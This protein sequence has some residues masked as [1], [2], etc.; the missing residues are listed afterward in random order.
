MEQ[1]HF[2]ID[3]QTEILK[4][5][6]TDSNNYKII[7]LYEPHYFT[8]REHSIIAAAFKAYYKEKNRLPNK[9]M[10]NETIRKLITMPRYQKDIKLI[11]KEQLSKLVNKI[12]R[13][14]CPN[15]EEI[16]EESKKFTRYQ[17]LREI[18]EKGD[19]LD[20]TRYD[21]FASSIQQAISFGHEYE[22]QKGLFL[23]RDAKF[24]HVDRKLSEPTKPLPY[25]QWNR[26]TNANGYEKG[27]VVC[28]VGKEKDFKTGFLINFSRECMKAREKILY[29]DLENNESPLS[30]RAEQSL[31]KKDKSEIL[32]G[33]Y[34]EK[35]E[36]LLRR[37]KRVGAELYFRRLPAYTSTCVTIQKVID[38][39]RLE[40]GLIFN[41][42]VVDYV[43]LLGCQGQAKD[44]TIR[45]SNATV[46]L[47]NLAKLN[48]F[49]LIIT[50]MHVTREGEDKRKATCY[51]PNDISKCKDIGRHVDALVG[52]NSTPEE[53]EAGI[54]RLE[55]IEQRDGVPNGRVVFWVNKAKQTLTELS[56]K[57]VKEYKA[58]V[59]GMD[60]PDEVQE[61]RKKVKDV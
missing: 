37:Y 17:K 40:H 15:P 10:L 11:D 28:V 18:V 16:I 3:F 8:L 38:E 57:E 27:S 2:G 33:Q 5:T 19:L 32:S 36:K 12:Y 44:D 20:F 4:V 54:L 31:I 60:S 9:T 34:D 59:E 58:Q 22:K 30:I 24:R 43:G 47:K 23:V 51:V 55:I 26:L 21:E 1:F 61:K 50:A 52:L 53:D 7:N 48:D 42:V 56:R 6:A 45:I 41:K 14:P 39:A 25:W 35:L 29:I 49:D 13:T 46:E